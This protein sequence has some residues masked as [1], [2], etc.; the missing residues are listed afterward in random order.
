MVGA[1]EPALSMDESS[2]VVN[3]FEEVRMKSVYTDGVQRVVVKNKYAYHYNAK[4][5]VS[6]GRSGFDDRCDFIGTLFAAGFK[7]DKA[8]YHE[9]LSLRRLG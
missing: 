8:A 1:G 7:R 3:L 4:S 9:S 2:G 5:G 6:I